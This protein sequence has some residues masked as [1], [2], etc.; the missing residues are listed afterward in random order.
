[1]PLVAS[2]LRNYLPKVT[3]LLEYG[4]STTL[5]CTSKIK[6]PGHSPHL[7]EFLYL[8]SI[9]PPDRIGDIKITIPAPHWYHLQ[10]KEGR[11]YA[12]GVYLSDEEYFQ[13]IAAAYQI[14]LQI[15][16]DAGLRRVQIDDPD[17]SCA[18]DPYRLLP[19]QPPHQL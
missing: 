5:R 12:D 11:A 19:I 3:A 15:L 14:E 13:D 16:H 10:Y 2:D 1:M 7:R 17:L 18:L 6:H 9:V 8:K 4:M